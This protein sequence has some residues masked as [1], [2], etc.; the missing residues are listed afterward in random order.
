M[1]ESTST[2][3]ITSHQLHPLKSMIHGFPVYRTIEGM[4][5]LF[6]PTA[7]DNNAFNSVMITMTPL[8]HCTT[9]TYRTIQR[10]I[11]GIDSS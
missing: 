5:Q 7:F 6:S 8:S 11:Y 9:C 3:F 1:N 10:P 2:T 4:K